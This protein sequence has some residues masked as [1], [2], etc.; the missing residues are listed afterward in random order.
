VGAAGIIIAGL[1]QIASALFLLYAA[2]AFWPPEVTVSA[3]GATA[4]ASYS[5]Q[6]LAWSL[7][8]SRESGLFIIVAATGALG[9]MVHT[10]RS[11]YF[12]V[13]NRY[14]KWSWML[15][16][17]LTPVVG[18]VLAVVF[19]VVLRGGL[20]SGQANSTAVSP[21]GFAAVAGLVGLFSEQA[22]L[23]LQQVFS[24]LFAPVPPGKDHGPATVTVVDFSPRSG[25][26]GTSVAISGTGFQ[27]AFEV[28]F[29]A[30]T[31]VPV[32]VSEEELRVGV[33]R[34]ATTAPITVRTNL[35][36]A[37]SSRVFAVEGTA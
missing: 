1:L 7:T 23:K 17:V 26:V 34:G 33:P 15:M 37:T 12:Y 19:Y 4:P 11:F 16:Y 9:A 30:G 2:V 22:V 35:S 21:F 36:G 25:P 29:G 6:L 31:A 5:A 3:A 27:Q 24:V 28:D 13:G 18:S 14:L 10:L 8:I 32:V 20:I